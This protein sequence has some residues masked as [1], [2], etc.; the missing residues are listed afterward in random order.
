MRAD[1]LARQPA[2]PVGAARLTI[3]ARTIPTQPGRDITDKGNIRM[4]TLETPRTHAGTGSITTSLERLH[5]WIGAVSKVAAGPKDHK[6]ALQYILVA[7]DQDG[8]TVAVATDAYTLAALRIES[9]H[10]GDP[11]IVPARDVVAAIKIAYKVKAARTMSATLSCDGSTWTLASGGDTWGGPVTNDV[12]LFPRWRALLDNDGTVE[13][14]GFSAT[15]FGVIADM[16]EML[17]DSAA[18]WIDHMQN[19][20]SMIGHIVGADGIT[21]KVAAMSMRVPSK[22]PTA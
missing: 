12:E 18:L 22:P 3:G 4:T 21:G 19:R 6:T 15:T 1:R 2:L 13:P 7:P 14:A 17:G 10:D 9:E 11:F 5:Q 16:L 8:G 20:R